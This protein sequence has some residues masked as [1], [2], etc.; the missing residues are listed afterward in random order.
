[1]LVLQ[2]RVVPQEEFTTTK[3]AHEAF[4]RISSLV[5]SCLSDSSSKYIRKLNTNIQENKTNIFFLFSKV[6]PIPSYSITADDVRDIIIV[7]TMIMTVIP[8]I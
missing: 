2:L 8:L 3:V 5:G 6:F 4:K 7:V 1:M